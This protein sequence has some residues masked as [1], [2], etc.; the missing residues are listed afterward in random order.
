MKRH[1]AVV[2]GADTDIVFT[3]DLG[4]VVGVDAVDGEGEGG[5]AKVGVGGAVESELGNGEELSLGVVL[6]FM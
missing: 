5:C 1:S 4:K 6:E 2:A 3:E